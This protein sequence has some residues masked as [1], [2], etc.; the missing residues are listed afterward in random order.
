ML[1][2]KIILS[3]IQMNLKVL[4]SLN[5]QMMSLLYLFR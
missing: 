5:C 4:I 1:F 3:F 2:L